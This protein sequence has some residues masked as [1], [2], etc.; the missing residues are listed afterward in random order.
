MLG[1]PPVAALDR[2]SALVFLAEREDGRR[3]ADELRSSGRIE[4]RE[5]CLR[6]GN[7][8]IL[9]V[10]MNI[11]ANRG[12]N[13]RWHRDRCHPAKTVRG[14][15]SEKRQLMQLLFDNIPDQVYIKDLQHRFIFCNPGCA[16][17]MGKP[18][19]AILGKTDAD[20]FPPNSQRGMRQTNDA[21]LRMAFHW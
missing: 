14:R 8:S 1:L 16:K 21:F 9:W 12:N 19:N 10:V 18:V 15:A 2:T 3:I 5:L 6:R 20:F 7:G 13:S 4:G 11:V 17:I